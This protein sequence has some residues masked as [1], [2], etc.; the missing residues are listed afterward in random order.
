MQP[1]TKAVYPPLIDMPPSDPDII[2]TALHGAKRLTNERCQ[3]NA[4]LKSDRQL[5]K[6]AVE[7]KW[8]YPNEFSDVIVRLGGMHMLMSFGGAVGTMMQGSGLYVVLESTLAGVTKMLS[9]KKF[10]QNAGAMRLIVE[11]LLR[12][13][14]SDGSINIMEKL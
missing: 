6:V 4:V 13:I 8:A 7:V 2:S 1:K 10:P 3:N 12:S 11:E 9:G 14:T 5:Y